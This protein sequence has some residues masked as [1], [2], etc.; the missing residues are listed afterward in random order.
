MFNM[1]CSILFGLEHF[2]FSHWTFCSQFHLML[3]AGDRPF[4]IVSGITLSQPVQWGYSA[5]CLVS[6]RHGCH[7]SVAEDK[8]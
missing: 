5:F 3:I 6:V 8:V 1:F 7:L 2:L 4:S